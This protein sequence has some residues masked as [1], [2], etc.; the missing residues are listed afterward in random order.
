VC[1]VWVTS[2]YSGRLPFLLAKLNGDDNVAVAMFRIPW[3][4]RRLGLQPLE[5]FSRLNANH[6]RWFLS[7]RKWTEK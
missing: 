1:A 6:H 4:L 7:A 5:F 2:H 3:A